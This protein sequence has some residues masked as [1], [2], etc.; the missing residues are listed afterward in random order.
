MKIEIAP[1]TIKVEIPNYGEF[2]VI[3][4]GAGA[5]AEMRIIGRKI[6]ELSQETKQYEE[7]VKR[8]ENGEEID[9]NSDE[10]K[11][12]LELY[13]KLAETYDELKDITI[14]KMRACF[15]GKNVEKLFTDF[16]YDQ[17]LEIHGKAIGNNE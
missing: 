3:P 8:E 13:K 12:A 17:I 9:Q 16:T 2:Q 14:E 15:R 5:E 11:K 1:K 4:L 10:Y 7:L 6:S